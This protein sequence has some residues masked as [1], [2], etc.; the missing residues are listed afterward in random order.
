MCMRKHV[1]RATLAI[2]ALAWASHLQAQ[3]SS[4][5]PALTIEQLIEIKHPSDPIWSPDGKHVA[6]I[7]DRAVIKNLFVAS[8]DGRGQTV[9]LTSFPEGGVAGAFWSEDGDS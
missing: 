1:R 6:F 7:W 8:A 3:S 2:T 9:A 5:K 4:R